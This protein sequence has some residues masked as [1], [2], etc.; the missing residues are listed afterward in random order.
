MSLQPSMSH[1][2]NFKKFLSLAN[3]KRDLMNFKK[4]NRCDTF[5]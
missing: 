5:Y 3:V 2:M 1:D 4:I